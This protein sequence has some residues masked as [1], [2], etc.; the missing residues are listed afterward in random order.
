MGSHTC[1]QQLVNSD[2]NEQLHHE[3]GALAVSDSYS[4]L[5]VYIYYIQLA[6]AAYMDARLLLAQ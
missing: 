6:Q 5:R 2:R 4:I 3:E 1:S